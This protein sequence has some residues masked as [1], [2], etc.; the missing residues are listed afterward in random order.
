MAGE[1]VVPPLQ[2][3]SLQFPPLPPRR[4]LREFVESACTDSGIPYPY[5]FSAASSWFGGTKILIKGWS[6]IATDT[7]SGALLVVDLMEIVGHWQA[8][9]DKSIQ[10]KFQHVGTALKKTDM[11]QQNLYA[12][13]LLEAGCI[14]MDRSWKVHCAAMYDILFVGNSG[15]PCGNLELVVI[16][17]TYNFGW[18]AAVKLIRPQEEHGRTLSTLDSTHHRL[19]RWLCLNIT[20]YSG[21]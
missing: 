9:Q 8:A 15:P 10:L 18:I 16:A 2:Q 11:L 5:V 14:L 13:P 17:G 21:W 20:S 7:K 19:K 1:A 4:R 3:F 12:Q 6:G